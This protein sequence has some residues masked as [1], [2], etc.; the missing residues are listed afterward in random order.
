MTSPREEVFMNKTSDML[1]MLYQQADAVANR[2]FITVKVAM[3]DTDN[4]ELT[5]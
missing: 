4:R 2:I 5:S 3:A 1:G